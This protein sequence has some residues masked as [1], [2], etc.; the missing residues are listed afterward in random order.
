MKV[1]LYGA[2]GYIGQQLSTL[3]SERGH[4]VFTSTTRLEHVHDV[5]KDLDE[6]QPDRVI[7]CTGRTHGTGDD[8]KTIGTIDYLELPG[9][10]VENLRDN[11]QGPLN[12]ALQCQ[13]RHIHFL[14]VGTGCIYT[15]Q[16]T[17]DGKVVDT[18]TED[19]PPNFTGSSYSAVKGVT[20]RLLSQCHTTLVLR[21]R[22]PITG[23]HHPRNTVTKLVS[24]PFI[25]SAANSVTCFSLLPHMVTMMEKGLTGVYNFCN[26]GSITNQEIMALYQKHVD[27]EHKFTLI[28]QEELA[29][30][31]PAK[32]SN[33][34]L[35]TTKLEQV[36]PDLPEA[37]TAVE[38]CMRSL[39]K[40]LQEP[41]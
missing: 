33:T 13:K 28:T 16:Y 34:V 5:I 26:K 40:E 32:R 27:P 19:D 36:F 23:H 38:E 24:Y 15:S 37:Y 20:D 8:G 4:E 31:L 7:G 21:I 2:T 39:K 35:D 29:T 6:I 17:A 11:L 30:R 25:H 22:L 41:Q 12:V 18:Y 10:L 14:Y 3:L 1:L 9:R